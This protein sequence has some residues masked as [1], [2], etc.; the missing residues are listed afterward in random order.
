MATRNSQS[1]G[2][3]LCPAGPYQDLVKSLIDNDPRLK[4]RDTKAVAQG[5]LW[6]PRKLRIV[7]MELDA[8]KSFKQTAEWSD[9]AKFRQHLESHGAS[10]TSQR[11]IILVE[12]L[13]P[14][15]ID[16][17]G[18]QFNIHPSFFVDHERVVVFTATPT[19]TSDTPSLPSCF[20]RN[21]T[22]T[23]LT[24]KYFEPMELNP[25]PWNFR[26]SCVD[27][28][29]HVGVFRLRGHISPVIVVRR[30]CSIWPI[31]HPGGGYTCR[32]LYIRHY[33]QDP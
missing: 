4:K 33:L 8:S 11:N 10:T 24:L 7:S 22:T 5:T 31:L 27:S 17:L 9:T 3:W 6:P 21:A 13:S 28:G 19:R 29:R 26:L 25:C 18:T 23:G 2:E 15:L 32:Y 1:D 16:I 20:R 12:G 14:D 30:K